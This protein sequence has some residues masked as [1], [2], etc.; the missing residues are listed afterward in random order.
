VKRDRV[1]RLG[2]LGWLFLAFG[3]IAT[4]LAPATSAQDWSPPTTVW[5]EDAGH[6]VDGLFLTD[7]RSYQA[8]YGQPISEEFKTKVALA[9]GKASTRTVQYFQNLAIAYVPDAKQD[10]WQVQA[11]PLGEEALK[12]DQ[13]KLAKLNLPSKGSCT[14]LTKDICTHFADN[15]HSVR[16]GFKEFWDANDGERLLG[17]PL[18]EEFVGPDKVTTQYFEHAVLLWTKKD[19]VTVRPIGSETA[20][21]L[22]IKTTKIA[23]PD[24]I[25]V[26]SEDLFVEPE[27]VG[28]YD[29]GSGPGPQ[30]G[31]YKEIVVSISAEA[32]WAYEDGDLVIS[33]LVSTGIGDVPETVTP[34][35]DWSIWEKLDSQTM[36]GTISGEYYRVPDVPYVMYFDDRGDALHGTYWHN[37][38]GNPMSHGC[39]NLPMDVAAFLYDWADI[40]T[41][42]TIIE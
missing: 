19:G 26:Y 42:V 3:L 16:M 9:G 27:G 25:P 5:V 17:L 4:V 35:G 2:A 20:K 12:A 36:E 23:E 18:T 6:T 24:G 31:G 28:G 1:A 13:A 21:R 7:W 32:M 34:L 14:G 33:S 22:K 37:N 38:F 10:G 8:L 30:Q 11:L 39:V 15:G 29:L 40:G 41:A